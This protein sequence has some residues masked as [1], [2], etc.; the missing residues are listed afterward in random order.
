MDAKNAHNYLS[1]Y[2]G[3]DFLVE[4]YEIEHTLGINDTVED[5]ARICRNNGGTL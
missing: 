3:I 5:M 2:G 1:R 4:M